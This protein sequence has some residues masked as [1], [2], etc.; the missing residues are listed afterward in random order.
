MVRWPAPTAPAV[1]SHTCLFAA[2]D[3]GQGDALYIRT[4]DGQDVLIDGGPGD[5]VVGALE[6][7][8][9]LGDHDLELV[10][11]THPDSDHIAGLPSVLDRYDVQTIFVTG[12]TADTATDR[13]WRAA[14]DTEHAARKIVRGGQQYQLGADLTLRVLWPTEAW[15]ADTKRVDAD[16]N[17]TSI[18]I[19]ATCAGSTVLLTGDASTDVEEQLLAAHVDVRATMVK[20]GHHGSKYSSSSEFLA[21]VKPALAIVSAGKDNRYGHPSPSVIERL[22]LLGI[23]VRRTDTEGT[24]L[25]HTDGQGG[26]K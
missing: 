21:A 19:Q 14:I 6:T 3:V 5:R 9:P 22:R 25:F 16:R 10:V 24:I 15:M 13:R 17:A 1:N 7:V 23:P 2:L 4:S 20:L 26:W 11:A 8:M 12:V 18:V